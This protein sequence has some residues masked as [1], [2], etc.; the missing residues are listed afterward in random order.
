MPN[1]MMDGIVFKQV[2]ETK[3]KDYQDNSERKI[4]DTGWEA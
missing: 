3:Q 2:E 1:E 4:C